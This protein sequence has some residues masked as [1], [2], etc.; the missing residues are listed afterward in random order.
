MT[1]SPDKAFLQQHQ[2]EFEGMQEER[3]IIYNAYKIKKINPL[4]F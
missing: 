2:R 4:N 3:S 1:L